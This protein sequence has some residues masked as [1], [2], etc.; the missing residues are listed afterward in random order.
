MT[1]KHLFSFCLSLGLHLA[2]FGLPAYWGLGGLSPGPSHLNAG[3]GPSPAGPLPALHIQALFP[4]PETPDSAPESAAVQEAVQG[5][6][7]EPVQELLPEP[8]T[9]PS[10]P[11]PPAPLAELMLE[12]RAAAPPAAA[13]PPSLSGAA[14]RAAAGDA[15]GNEGSGNAGELSAEAEYLARIRRGIQAALR[16]PPQARRRGL[17]GAVEYAFVISATGEA[18]DITLR[19]S[20][21]QPLLDEAARA[22]ILRAS[23]FPPPPAPLRVSIPI[24]FELSS[25]AFP[26]ACA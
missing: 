10:S 23:P 5:P 25:R 12:Q 13:P 22:A 18:Q 16:Y 6:V 2:L 21:G 11:A 17:K 7:A 1:L 14:G 9:A 19:L 8:R 4:A 15:A 24:A 26:L 3:A 20:S